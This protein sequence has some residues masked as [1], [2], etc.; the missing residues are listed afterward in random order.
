MQSTCGTV[1]WPSR[2]RGLEEAARR[3]MHEKKLTLDRVA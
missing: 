3:M 2:Q 1:K